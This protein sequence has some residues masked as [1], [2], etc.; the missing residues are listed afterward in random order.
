MINFM[1]NA[2]VNIYR[3]WTKGQSS[4]SYNLF[5]EPI[6][7]IITTN[8]IVI[9]ASLK[10]RI[11]QKPCKM[12]YL[13]TGERSNPE[14]LMYSDKSS[15]LKEEDRVIDLGKYTSNSMY[16]INSILTAYDQIGKVD[17]YES[18]LRMP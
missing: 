2:T 12:E 4:A 9:S 18:E 8:W 6:Y 10:V 16:I 7:G 5:N 3:K 11:D 14:Y 13:P 17:H 1:S 15:S